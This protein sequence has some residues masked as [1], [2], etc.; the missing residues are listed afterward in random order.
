[1]KIVRLLG[2]SVASLSLLLAAGCVSLDKVALNVVGDALT[3]DGSN[4]V[5]TGDNDPKLVGDALPF[6]I[7]MYESLASANP[8]HPALKRSVGMLYVMYANAFVAGPADFYPIERLDEK[9]AAKKRALNLYLRGKD[10]VLQGLDLRYPGFQQAWNSA[11]AT[12]F[13]PFIKRLKKADVGYLY[14]LCAGQLAAFALQPMNLSLG[15]NVPKSMALLNAAYVLDPDYQK[16]TLDELLVSV[17][18]SVPR[19]LG[20]I[21]ENAQLYYDRALQKNPASTGAWLAWATSI[22]IATQN[23]EHF[24]ELMNKVLTVDAAEDPNSTL[25]TLLNQERAR[26]YLSQLD[27]LFI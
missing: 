4:T 27:D 5:F 6:A 20:G 8:T 26:W 15:T 24:V 2:F 25:P 1:M 13:P 9:N 10:F 17:N 19:E 18:A 16:S 23:R 11:D 21:P 14:W 7:K 12:A 3:A 22:D